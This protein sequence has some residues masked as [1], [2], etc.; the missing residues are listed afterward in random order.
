MPSREYI[1]RSDIW[2]LDPNG[3]LLLLFIIENKLGVENVRAIAQ[4]LKNAN[5]GAILWAGTGDMSVSY[6][7]DAAA[8]ERGVQ[9]I[10]AAGKEFGLPVGVNG[11][12]D[13]KQRYAQGARVFFNSGPASFASGPIP[14]EDRKAVGR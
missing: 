11:T 5:V 4:A 7:R 12:A 1:E 8:V 9:A 14:A 13:F 3:N 10:I 2:K 6:G